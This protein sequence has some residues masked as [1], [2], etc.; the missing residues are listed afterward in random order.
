VASTGTVLGGKNLNPFAMGALNSLWINGWARLNLSVD[1]RHA[2]VSPAG[3]SKIV[4]TLTG[5][6]VSTGA[7]VTYFGLPVVGFAVQSYSTT[8]L[9][10]V[11]P[12]VLSNY[13]GSFGHKYT[14]RIA[15]SQ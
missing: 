15:V 2:L 12:N 7:A 11:D 13:G 3:S 14:R 5:D 6:T 1:P 8:G 10:G 4:D 9:P